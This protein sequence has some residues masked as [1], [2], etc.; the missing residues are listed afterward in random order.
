MSHWRD[1]VLAMMPTCALM[2]L[3][4]SDHTPRVL[5]QRSGFSTAARGQ[6]RTAS[7]LPLINV[8]VQLCTVM[9]THILP[10]S[11]PQREYSGPRR[12]SAGSLWAPC[13]RNMMLC[14]PIQNIDSGDA[15]INNIVQWSVTS[16]GSVVS[17]EASNHQG[18]ESLWGKTSNNPLKRSTM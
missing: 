16:A 1:V 12:R 11:G 6:L 4:R 8:A 18:Q 5:R 14:R 13:V 3:W 10:A 7:P 15:I 2:L 9:W 17:T